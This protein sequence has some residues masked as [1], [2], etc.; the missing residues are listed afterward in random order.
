MSKKLPLQSLSKMLAGDM[1]DAEAPHNERVCR[2]G[3]IDL[4]CP[5][6][7]DLELYDNALKRE[8]NTQ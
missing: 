4:P 6:H 8:E 3:L 7:P 5:Q 1:P 2:N